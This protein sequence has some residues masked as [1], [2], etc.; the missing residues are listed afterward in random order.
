MFYLVR[1][2]HS[3]WWANSYILP[4]LWVGEHKKCPRLTKVDNSSYINPLTSFFWYINWKL[5]TRSV[6]CP[7]CGTFYICVN[8]RP[9]M[10]ASWA[11]AYILKNGSLNISISSI[12]RLHPQTMSPAYLGASWHIIHLSSFNL[13]YII[14]HLPIALFHVKASHKWN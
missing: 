2:A 13:E 9:A 4:N 3:V 5:F 8:V 11:K 6:P 7:W 10:A 12:P 1:F 14:L